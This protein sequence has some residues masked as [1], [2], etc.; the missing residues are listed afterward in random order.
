M[1][2][3]GQTLL[4]VVFAMSLG[5]LVLVNTAGRALASIAR[6]TQANYFQKAVVAAESAAEIYLARPLSDLPSLASSCPVTPQL[7]TIDTAAFPASCIEN[8]GSESRAF[9]GVEVYPTSAESMSIT[10][11]PGETIHI[12]LQGLNS[13]VNIIRVCWYGVG[14]PTYSNSYYFLYSGL[15]APYTVNQDLIK[16]N[17]ADSWCSGA[18]AGYGDGKVSSTASSSAG[19]SCYQVNIPS[20]PVALRIF[21]FPGGAQ[22]KID[23]YAAGGVSKAFPAQ[24]YRIISIGEVKAGTGGS[25]DLKKVTRKKVV[26]ERT[27]PFPVGPWW[28]FAVTSVT[29]TVSI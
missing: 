14:S 7:S 24:G 9:M 8:I 1:N 4:I 21:T 5:L 27:F 16:C 12:N 29:G 3:K 18:P 2:D 25:L 20:N 15:T 17:S 26:V 22:Y 11:Q 28:D 13:S 23:A 6:T 10:S 19:Y